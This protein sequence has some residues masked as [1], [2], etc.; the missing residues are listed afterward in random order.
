MTRLIISFVIAAALAGTTGASVRPAPLSQ[1][2]AAAA[3]ASLD[4]SLYTI[5][6]YSPNSHL[7]LR[8]VRPAS[9]G[10]DEVD[11]IEVILRAMVQEQNARGRAH[12]SNLTQ[13]KRQYVAVINAKGEKEVW[14][15][16]FCQLVSPA[17]RKEI[18]VVYDGGP[19]FFHLVVN[20]SKHQYY[21]VMINGDA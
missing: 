18:V 3:A 10:T 12:L 4:T 11:S 14:V 15:N 9:L 1:P 7:P 20:L 19:C 16:C 13:Y 6:P 17:W 21:S 5:L 8:G 2:S